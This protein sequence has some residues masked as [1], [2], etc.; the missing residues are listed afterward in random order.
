MGVT[1]VTYHKGVEEKSKT[2]FPSKKEDD[3][4]LLCTKEVS[5]EVPWTKEMK[6][7]CPLSK[8]GTRGFFTLCKGGARQLYSVQ[9][10]CKTVS[11]TKE[12]QDHYPIYKRGARR[13]Y[14]VQRRCN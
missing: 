11:C 2:V 3:T 1:D 5:T 4:V 14:P 6:D 13:L 12:M 10:R 9:M 8:R 7:N